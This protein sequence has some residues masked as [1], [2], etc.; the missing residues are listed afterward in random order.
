LGIYTTWLKLVFQSFS[1]AKD[2][3]RSQGSF[4]VRS[5]TKDFRGSSKHSELWNV[6]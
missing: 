3:I 4:K 2:A 6:I 1:F 5:N